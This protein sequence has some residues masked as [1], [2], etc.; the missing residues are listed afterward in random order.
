M[1]QLV[2]LVE[3][4]DRAEI[5]TRFPREH[6][7]CGRSPN[8]PQLTLTV[9]CLS[10]FFYV[11]SCTDPPHT[12]ERRLILTNKRSSGFWGNFEE[13]R[14][15]ESSQWVWPTSKLVFNVSSFQFGFSLIFL[16]REWQIRLCLLFITHLQ[17]MLTTYSRLTGFWGLRLQG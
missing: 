3:I 6:L 12:H 2:W 17:E 1:N 10:R 15:S 14:G 16:F 8:W 13:K 7:L 9:V 5:P 11:Y 4:V